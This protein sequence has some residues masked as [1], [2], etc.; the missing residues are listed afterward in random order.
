MHWTTWL[1]FMIM[2]AL[3]THDYD[4]HSIQS[5]FFWHVGSMLGC[6]LRPNINIM[7]CTYAILC[8]QITEKKVKK[9]FG[10]PCHQAHLYFWPK[11]K[12]GDNCVNKMIKG[13]NH[14]QVQLNATVLLYYILPM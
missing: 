8:I 6:T 14:Y 10:K 11:D 13:H 2:E 5:T 3:H 9:Y 4:G 7:I 12:K 1:Y